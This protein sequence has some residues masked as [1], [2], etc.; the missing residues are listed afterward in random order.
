MSVARDS[1]EPLWVQVFRR[2]ADDIASAALAPGRHL[3]S[4]RALCDRFGVS[5]IT[6]RRALRELAEQGLIAPSTGRGW[7]VAAEPVGEPANALM[8]F[9]ALGAA[10]GLRASARVLSEVRRPA[11]LDESEAFR[12]APGSEL[13]DLE[14]LRFLDEVP[15]A[16]NRALVAL[17]RAPALVGVDFAEASLFGVLEER[18]GLVPTRSECTVEALPAGEREA[19]LLE[20][21]PGRPL[22]VVSETVFDQH[23][24]PVA[25]GRVAYRGDRYRM[26]TTLVRPAATA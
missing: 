11:T 6:L 21:P 22:M 16:I 20:L 13:L 17:A 4:E 18:C 2:L 8:S 25:L 15:I 1:S 14:R 3:P 10:R 12:V 9:T 24:K 5:R 19:G 23:D 7:N 26:Q